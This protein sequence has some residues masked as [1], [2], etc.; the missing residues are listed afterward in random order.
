[1]ITTTKGTERAGLWRLESYTPEETLPAG[2]YV[3]GPETGPSGVE[4]ELMEPADR[5]ALSTSISV[6]A[7]RYL[8][9]RYGLEAPDVPRG[10]GLTGYSL[11]RMESEYLAAFGIRAGDYAILYRRREEPSEGYIAQVVL[12]EEDGRYTCFRLVLDQGEGLQYFHP[13]SSD[14]RLDI[15]APKVEFLAVVVGVLRL[16]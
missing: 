8:K 5:G 16:G 7:G 14:L 10:E 12:E 1:M 6:V 15:D 3:I 2:R 4:L 11:W 9:R 13:Q